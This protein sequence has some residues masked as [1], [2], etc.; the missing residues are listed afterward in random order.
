MKKL[1]EK[2]MTQIV[3]GYS[4]TVSSIEEIE[5][6]KGSPVGKYD[7]WEGSIYYIEAFPYERMTARLI[8]SF[9]NEGLYGNTQRTHEV[10]IID[11]YAT[12]SLDHGAGSVIR[13]NG[14]E[15]RLYEYV[16]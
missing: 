16:E 3:G 11:I 9:E 4:S 8:R 6:H 10:E 13:L 15:V 12:S 1:N 5:R 14:D 2:E 7:G